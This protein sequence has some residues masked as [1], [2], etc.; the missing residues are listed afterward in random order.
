MSHIHTT[1]LR[2]PEVSYKEREQEREQQ[3]YP[4]KQATMIATST[5]T[6]V[7]ISHW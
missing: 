3:A 1:P 6:A 4:M 5:V 2:P 7:E